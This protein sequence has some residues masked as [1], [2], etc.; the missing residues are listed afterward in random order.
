MTEMT[1]EAPRPFPRI[2]MSFGWII[3]YF[4]LQIIC[5]IAPLALKIAQDPSIAERFSKSPEEVMAVPEISV[6][7]IWS[8]V[9]SALLTL[10]LLWL[11]L[12]KGDRAE[13]IG[14]F[15]PSR[16]PMA[17]TL[18]LAAVLILG[19]MGLNWVYATYV[20][21]GVDL[22]GAIKALLEALPKDAFN[23]VLKFVA[24]ALLGPAIEE[25]LFRGYLQTALMK[26]FGPAIAITAASFIFA[27]VHME[28][29][30]IPALMA[31]GAAFGYLYYKT[32]SLKTNIALH[33]LNNAAALVFSST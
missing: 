21:P 28:P 17:Q 19:A 8:I 29:A 18:G 25:I 32:G 20:I 4:A 14:L 11:N 5:M 30:A 9:S 31:L 15:A 22:Q 27:L 33:M 13:Q 7:V 3:L 1:S 24:V 23:T 12:R 16:L 6:M 26:K 10:A 2:L